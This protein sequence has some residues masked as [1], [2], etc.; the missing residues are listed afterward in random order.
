LVSSDAIWTLPLRHGPRKPL[1]LSHSCFAV[2]PK[3]TTARGHLG[4]WSTARQ[5]GPIDGGI[6]QGWWPRW[7]T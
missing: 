6:F 7:K 5:V 4:K 3:N 1:L 2:Q